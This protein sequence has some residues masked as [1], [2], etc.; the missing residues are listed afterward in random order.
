MS[1]FE[2]FLRE[3][4]NADRIIRKI[5]DVDDIKKK[6]VSPES[7]KE[8]LDRTEERPRLTKPVVPLGETIKEITVEGEAK[9]YFNAIYNFIKEKDEIQERIADLTNRMEKLTEKF[10]A[11]NPEAR[12]TK[13][14]M[15]ALTKKVKIE[16]D[17]AINS[18]Y[19]LAEEVE[20]IDDK[21]YVIHP[22]GGKRKLQVSVYSYGGGIPKSGIYN[23]VYAIAEKLASSAGNSR[24]ARKFRALIR[25]ALEEVALG[26]GKIGREI[27]ES[28][29]EVL[30][31]FETGS[32]IS[33][34]S[35][36]EVERLIDCLA[37]IAKSVLNYVEV[38][39]LSSYKHFSKYASPYLRDL[40]VFGRYINYV[41]RALDVYFEIWKDLIADYNIEILEYAEI[42]G[43]EFEEEEEEEVEERYERRLTA[44]AYASL[45]RREAVLDTSM[46]KIIEDFLSKFEEMASAIEETLDTI[47]DIITK[48]VEDKR[49][50]FSRI[51]KEEEETEDETDSIGEIEV[52]IDT[53]DE[54][55]E[56]KEEDEEEKEKE[57]EDEVEKEYE[58]EK[59][60][61]E[62]EKEE[63]EEEDEGEKEKEEEEDEGEKE[64]EEEEDEENG[65]ENDLIGK[66]RKDI[67]KELFNRNRNRRKS[68]YREKKDEK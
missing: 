62:E 25:E 10:Y 2:D 53:E 33:S 46:Q 54:E 66:E 23:I 5:A 26:K 21:I 40:L 61:D 51:K 47:T 32:I 12:E 67:R 60:E 49:I 15:E 68:P 37:D 59:E 41:I 18:L 63:D 4:K 34:S 36:K 16:L 27:I 52:F 11:T 17:K 29:K 9:E 28:C 65:K 39:K 19:N 7:K 50:D 35:S 20:L 44:P 3:K 43:V 31:G 45:Q 48:S 58:E 24:Q 55:E 57:E 8:F 42:K 22:K 56:E 14:E 6:I 64:K 38:R 13:E 30:I 1:R